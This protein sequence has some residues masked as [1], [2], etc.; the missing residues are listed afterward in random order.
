M[1]VDMPYLHTCFKKCEDEIQKLYEELWE[2]VGEYFTV[3][4]GTVIADYFE[5]KLGER[6]ETTDKSFLKKHKEDRV[7]QLITRL[8]RLEKWQSTYISRIIEVAQYDNHFYTQYGQFN[9]VSGRLGSD[10]Q[11]FPKERILTEEGEH[12]EKENGEGKAPIEYEL[13]SPRRAFIVE[14]GNYNKIAYFDLSQIELRV[15]AN[16]TV[17]LK[18]PDLNLCRAYM[19]FKCTHYITG[20]EYRFDTKEERARWYEKR[21]WNISLASG[22]RRKLDSY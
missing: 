15:Q 21:R 9:T 13:F 17:L 4:Q 8:R 20:E 14:G 6:P 19:P 16:Y 12:Y 10:A 22:K 1:K 2:I 5:K 18:R 11:Q 3:S 7:S